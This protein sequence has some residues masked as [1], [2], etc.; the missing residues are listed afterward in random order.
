M[1]G[2]SRTTET[3]KKGDYLYRKSD[4]EKEIEALR[5]RIAA[6]EEDRPVPPSPQSAAPPPR[7]A[8]L[9]R[10]QI[11]G[12]GESKLWHKKPDADFIRD[13]PVDFEG[14]RRFLTVK[15]DAVNW[16]IE[17]LDDPNKTIV[18]IRGEGAKPIPVSAPWAEFVAW[19]RAGYPTKE[20]A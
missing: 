13:W 15:R 14:K 7:R 3:R 9:T 12:K 11:V 5:A 17:T 18:C 20:Q 4:D 1:D 19:W 6:L 8:K 16:C 10:E 2:A